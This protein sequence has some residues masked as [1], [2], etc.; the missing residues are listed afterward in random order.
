VFCAF[1]LF[2]PKGHARVAGSRLWDV[3]ELYS[4]AS[5]WLHRSE[6]GTPAGRM[7]GRVVVVVMVVVAVAV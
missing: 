1:I 3:P 7:G 5:G 6:G 4:T 2:S